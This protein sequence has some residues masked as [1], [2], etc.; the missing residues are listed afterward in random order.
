MPGHVGVPGNELA[1]RLA[2][3]AA[4]KAAILSPVPCTDVFPVI[5][6]AIIAIWKERWDARGATSKMGKVTR[7]VSHP[8]DYTTVRER[9]LQTAL[10]ITLA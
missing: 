10:A 4:G 5:R 1:D 6:E 8:W 3:K 9:R 2:R 7:T